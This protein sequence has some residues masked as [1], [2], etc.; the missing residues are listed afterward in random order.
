VTINGTGF[1]AGATVTFGGTAATSVVVVN[2]TKI[3]AVTPAHAVGAV[4]VVVTNTDTTT[5][6]SI[7]GYTY[8]PRQF[9]PNGD[10]IVNPADIFYLVNYLFTSGPAPA[11]AAGMLS[12]D[13]NG[14]GVVNPAD[15]FYAVNYLFSSGPQPAATTP[16]ALSTTSTGSSLRGSVTLG[17]AVRRDGRWIVPVIVTKEPGSV[18]PEALSLQVRFDGAVSNAEVHRLNGIETTFEISRRTSDGLSYLLVLGDHTPVQFDANGSAVVAELAVQ[19]SGRVK[20]ELDPA[21]TMLTDRGGMQKAVSTNGT[22]KLGGTS[23]GVV[24]VNPQSPNV[25]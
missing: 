21:L 18:L 15:I 20:L 1:A 22:L 10:G 5:A 8:R 14:D 4:N 2:S 12:G 23:V 17:N 24:A 13:A 19:T 9:D 7:G 6:T 25:N 16:G 3:T 11:G